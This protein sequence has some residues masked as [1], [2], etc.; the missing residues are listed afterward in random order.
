MTL[1][2]PL[3]PQVIVAPRS[4]NLLDTERIQGE[5]PDVLPIKES[6]IKCVRAVFMLVHMRMRLTV[7]V[8][9]TGS[10]SRSGSRRVH[11]SSTELYTNG[12]DDAP[13]RLLWGSLGPDLLARLWRP[14]C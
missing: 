5:F 3:H 14:E 2:P 4:N 12:R 7:D 6:L 8:P 11:D 10:N 13:V 9:N 1:V